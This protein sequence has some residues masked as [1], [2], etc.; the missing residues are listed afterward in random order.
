LRPRGWMRCLP[1]TGQDRTGQDRPG[2]VQHSTASEENGSVR[3]PRRKQQRRCSLSHSQ[4]FPKTLFG[5]RANNRLSLS[6]S[7][8]FSLQTPV[9]TRNPISS[10][11]EVFG[12]AGCRR[13]C[14]SSICC[15][16]V[17]FF[18]LAA[19]A[20]SLAFFITTRRCVR[21]KSCAR[22]GRESEREKI[23][24]RHKNLHHVG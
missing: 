11:V 19:F 14:T 24:T 2:Q 22:G 12:P 3:E 16:V 6:S 4:P 10:L 1:S 9:Q 7:P 23:I 5:P 21:T 13:H 18:S 8:P 20:F 15:R 17:F